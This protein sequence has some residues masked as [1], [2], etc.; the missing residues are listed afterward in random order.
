MNR[1]QF[2]AKF[3][4]NEEVVGSK[5][6]QHVGMTQRNNDAPNF[7]EAEQVSDLQDLNPDST[8]KAMDVTVIRNDG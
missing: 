7:E 1:D 5:Q 4:C 2:S 6:E 3:K 8:P